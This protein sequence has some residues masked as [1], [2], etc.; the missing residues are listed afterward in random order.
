MKIRIAPQDS[1]YQVLLERC[2]ESLPYEAW[3][4]Y[5][6]GDL[7]MDSICFKLESD[8]AVALY[9]APNPVSRSIVFSRQAG[10]AMPALLACLAGL[11][12]AGAIGFSYVRTA[13]AEIKASHDRIEQLDA[14]LTREDAGIDAAIKSLTEAR[15]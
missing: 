7:Y 1:F 11:I 14:R 13:R 9:G 12:V 2:I 5:S 6:D 10:N 8:R 15:K 3:D 4:V